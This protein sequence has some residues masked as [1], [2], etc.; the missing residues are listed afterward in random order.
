MVWN[1]PRDTTG[2]NIGLFI[3]NIF[4]G[5]IY[6]FVEKSEI[7]NCGDDNTVYSSGKDIPKRPFFS[8]VMM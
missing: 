8:L 1:L 4:I 5:D 2:L 6:I 3:F 7:F